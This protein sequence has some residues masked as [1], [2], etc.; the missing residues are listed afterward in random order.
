[1]IEDRFLPD[2]MPQGRAVAND[3]FRTLLACQAAAQLL[4]HLHRLPEIEALVVINLVN[5][6]IKTF[7]HQL[8]ERRQ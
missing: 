2:K 6:E 7:L 1:M 8:K 3:N 5:D 4:H